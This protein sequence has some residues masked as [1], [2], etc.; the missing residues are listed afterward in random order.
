MSDHRDPHTGLHSEQG[1]L[2]GEHPGRA[3]EPDRQGARP[4]VAGVREAGPAPGGAV[5]AGV[6]VQHGGPHGGRAAAAGYRPGRALRA[7]PAGPR[8]RVHRS[9]LPCGGFGGRAAAGGG[10]RAQGGEAAGESGWARPSTWSTRAGSAVRVVSDTHELRA[11]PAPGAA[12]AQRRPRA[13]PRTNATQRPPREPARVQRL[14]H[15]VLQT[16]RYRE[17]LDWYLHHLGLIVSDF[18]YYP[19]QRERGP[20]MSFIRCD[21][22]ATP[23]DHHTLAH[24][25]RPGQPLRALGLPGRRPG[26]AGRGRRVPARPGLPPLLGHRPAHPGQPDLRLLARPGRV[27]GRALQRRR[28]VRQHP[29]ARLGADD[30]LRPRAVG[31]ARHQGLPRHRAGPRGPARTARRSLGAL[32]ERQRVRPRAACAAC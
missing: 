5:R 13:S 25:A 14:G 28:P 9:G 1:A 16:T 27:P 30:R 10:D 23:T 7:D 11:L 4:R 15:V 8:S 26:R 3:A 18:L 17:T 20:V 12:H 32:R 2:A 21:R 31:A 19:G 6:R 22:G 24:G 29:R